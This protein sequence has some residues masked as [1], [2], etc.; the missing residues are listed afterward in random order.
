MLF[1]NGLFVGI[2]VSPFAHLSVHTCNKTYRSSLY[3]YAC[4]RVR[5][6]ALRA[7]LISLL[8]S[9][10]RGKDCMLSLFWLKKPHKHSLFQAY[11]FQKA[12][13]SALYAPYA[14][15]LE[16]FVFTK[17]SCF[18]V[19]SCMHFCRPC[20]WRFVCTAAG[21]GGLC[22]HVFGGVITPIF[23][24]ISAALRRAHDAAGILRAAS[25]GRCSAPLQCVWTASGRGPFRC[26]P[27]PPA[28]PH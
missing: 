9:S 3:P 23:C 19:C 18:S 1:S 5:A 14:R 15:F 6:G 10:S 12:R 20:R 17:N 7:R 13:M 4:K 21:F 28:R 11:N 27:A 8:F 25:S 26:C 22:M 24:A 2:V 16:S